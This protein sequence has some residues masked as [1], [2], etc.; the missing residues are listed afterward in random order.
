[1]ADPTGSI[2]DGKGRVL[3]VSGPIIELNLQGILPILEWG[4]PDGLIHKFTA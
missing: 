2:F 4:E 3:R 1:M